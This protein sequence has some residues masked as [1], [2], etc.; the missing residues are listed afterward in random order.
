MVEQQQQSGGLAVRQSIVVDAPRESA[1]AVF[2]DG[3]SSW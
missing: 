3:M 1:F 2:T